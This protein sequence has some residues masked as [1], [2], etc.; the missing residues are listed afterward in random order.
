MQPQHGGGGVGVGGGGGAGGPGGGNSSF[1][2][3]MIPGAKVGLVIGKGGETIKMLQEK[4]GAKMVV[5]QDGPNQE[6]EKPLRITG[7]P[8]KV[9]HARQLVYELLAEKEQRGGGGRGGAGGGGGRGGFGGGGRGGFN[10]RGGGGDES[11]FVVP[12]AKCG[13]IIGRGGETIKQINQTSGAHCELDRRPNDNPNEKIFIIRGSPQQIETAKQM[14]ADKLGQAGAGGPGG[15]TNGQPGGFGGG[16]GGGGGGYPGQWGGPQGPA[17]H[18]PFHQQHMNPGAM[19]MPAQNAGQPDYSQQW[20]EYYRN[21]GMH[22]EADAI[23]QQTKAKQ[24]AAAQG[25]APGVGQVPGGLAQA[26]PSAAAPAPNAAA[27]GGGAQNG[28][29]DYSAQWAQYYRSIGKIKEAELI[30]A[31]MKNKVRTRALLSFP[32]V[33]SIIRVHLGAVSFTLVYRGVIDGILFFDWFQYLFIPVLVE[34][35][36]S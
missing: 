20:I 19:G 32:R 4:S 25:G 22:Q 23:E 35:S 21:L 2:E 1:V 34:Y 9:E 12:A 17:Y 26:A 7:D 11:T 10:N 36:S 15:P 27:P 14:I 28:A 6:A 29:P 31:Q 8:Q 18:Q 30:E 24:A 16:G 33:V 13:V 5:I 3:V